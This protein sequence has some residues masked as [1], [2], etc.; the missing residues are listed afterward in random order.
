MLFN[1]SVGHSAQD[2]GSSAGP[3]NTTEPGGGGSGDSGVSNAKATVDSSSADDND[4]ESSLNSCDC[5]GGNQEKCNCDCSSSKI[6]DLGQMV[7]QV[8][9]GCCECNTVFYDKAC[10]DCGCAFCSECNSGSSPVNATESLN[11]KVV[12]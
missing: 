4:S 9:P 7:H 8:H 1:G 5:C 6:E 11:K 10:K 2:L 12:D 3:G